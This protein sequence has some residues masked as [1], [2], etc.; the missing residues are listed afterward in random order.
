MAPAADPRGSVCQEILWTALGM[1]CPSIVTPEWHQEEKAT[2]CQVGH[3]IWW[4]KTK[5]DFSSLHHHC[6]PRCLSLGELSSS[7]GLFLPQTESREGERS[8]NS[9]VQCYKQIT[10]VSLHTDSRITHST[11]M[12]RSENSPNCTEIS[13][14]LQEVLWPAGLGK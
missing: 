6:H 1:E 4:E 5:L 13:A 14:D 10:K 3:P 8:E 9:H 7:Q 11:G 2:L 12:H